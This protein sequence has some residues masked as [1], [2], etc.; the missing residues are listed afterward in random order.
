MPTPTTT[1]PAITPPTPPATTTTTEPTNKPTQQ[2]LSIPDLLFALT[3]YCYIFSAHLG[4]E[5][6]NK[7]NQNLV[8]ILENYS[9]VTEEQESEIATTSDILEDM[10]KDNDG[11][12]QLALAVTGS[13]IPTPP[14]DTED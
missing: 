12:K 10:K 1:P 5:A 6:I 8:V 14:I 2:E 9:P 13:E 3:C 4:Y 7:L 11:A